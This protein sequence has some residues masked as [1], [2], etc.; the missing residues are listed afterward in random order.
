MCGYSGE[1]MIVGAL[2]IKGIAIAL[3]GY[4]AEPLISGLKKLIPII[5]VSVD[6]GI[7]HI[8]QVHEFG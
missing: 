8:M 5:S 4:D 2:D 6:D 3:S 1:N 7:D